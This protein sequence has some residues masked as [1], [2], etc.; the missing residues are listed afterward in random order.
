[1]QVSDQIIQVL[2]KIG[3]KIGVAID[4]SSNNI[5]PYLQ[6]LTQRYVAYRIS[7]SIFWIAVGV[8]IG[9]VGVSLFIKL[10]KN[11][12]FGVEKYRCSSDDISTRV[13]TYAGICLI[14][15]IG[16]CIINTQIIN[17]ITCSVF[18]EKIIL[19]ELLPLIR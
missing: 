13:L 7:I 11:K 12:A 10:S 8:L 3:E 19:K 5:L 17:I 2:D 6:E 15:I 9:S 16:M 4:W 14:I 1:M 18:P